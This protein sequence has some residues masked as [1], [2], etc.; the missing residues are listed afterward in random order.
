[1]SVCRVTKGQRIRICEQQV[2]R[3][4]RAQRHGA[5]GSGPEAAGCVGFIHPGLVLFC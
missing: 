3:G 2:K 5:A 1:M 4:R